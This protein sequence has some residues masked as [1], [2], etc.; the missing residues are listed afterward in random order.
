MINESSL[1]IAISTMFR[2]NLDFLHTIVSQKL[3]TGISILVINQ[4]DSEKELKSTQPNITVINT[5]E[6]GLAKSRN[7]AIRNITTRY[8]ILTDDDVFLMSDFF[9]KIQKGFSTFP[10]ACVIRFQA[11]K[12]NNVPFSKYPNKPIANLSLFDR[13]GVSSIE[14]VVNIDKLKSKKVFFDEYFGLGAVFGNALEQAFIDNV[15]K[16]NLQ[17]SYYPEIIVNHPDDCSGRD[18]SSDKLYY[19]NGA[20]A[21]KMFGKFFKFWAVIFFFFKIKQSKIKLSELKHFYA[22]YVEGAKKYDSLIK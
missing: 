9:Y 2:D 7:M 10:D 18:S 19:V 16:N 5:L 11:V 17:V 15:S 3:Y 22:V 21:R 1:T 13:M 14:L 6:R 20:L 12:E 4:T 8:A